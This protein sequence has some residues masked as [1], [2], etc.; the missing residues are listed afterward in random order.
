MDRVTTRRILPA[1]CTALRN[2]QSKTIPAYCQAHRGSRGGNVESA[3]L[4]PNLGPVPVP[5]RTSVPSPAPVFFSLL[6]RMPF[7]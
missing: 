1:P 6:L 7:L 2:Y 4:R 3:R 5:G